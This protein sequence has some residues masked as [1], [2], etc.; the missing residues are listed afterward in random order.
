M[1]G[2]VLLAQVDLYLQDP[3]PERQRAVSQLVKLV[4]S[5]MTI[6]ADQAYYFKQK[7][8]WSSL[9]QPMG[10]FAPYPT[11]PLGG[12]MLALARYCEAAPDADAEDLLARLCR[13]VL[14]G[15][16][17]FDAEGRYRGH[18]H[19]GGILTALAGILRRAAI[20]GGAEDKRVVA[21]MRKA[22]D[23][24]IGHCSSWGWV[25]DG[26]GQEPGSCETCAIV[27]AIHAA[28]LLARHV[29]PKYFDV[30]ERFARNQLLENQVLRPAR[31]L[32]DSDFPGRAA[33]TRAL[34]GSWASY[35]QPNSLDNSTSAVEGCC[36][37][38]GIRGC[39]LVWESVLAKVND[40]VFVHLA[41]SRNSPWVEV[42]GY[43][44]YEGRLDVVVHDA[45]R[46][47]VRVPEWASD[48]VIRVAVDGRAV[49]TKL[50]ADRY[51]VLDDLRP[52]ERASLT[53]PLR[54]E[55][56]DET[57]TGRAYRVR[58]RGDT[59][60]AVEPPGR[61]YPLYEREGTRRDLAPI[62]QGTP[63]H[64]Q[65]GGPVHW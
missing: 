16:G 45:P 64:Q 46:L 12:V 55:E 36:L 49:A 62:V 35:S 63:Y 18:T 30:V 8:G 31:L 27:D 15:S 60:V 11:Y 28:I 41:L 52:G 13:F 47:R 42:I 44:P 5:K 54:N 50:D 29:D 57:V 21:R 4:R 65:I 33:V 17:T 25:P 38:S 9:D 14:D 43:Q 10:D 3:S 58:W 59:V 20:A 39:Y 23:W 37:G 22:F 56:R 7:P 51:L 6:D 61:R 48:D 24:T 1:A 26:L 2:R 40:T 53:Y 32:L 19:S 34:D